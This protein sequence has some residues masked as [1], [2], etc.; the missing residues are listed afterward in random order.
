MVREPVSDS[1]WDL[2]EVVESL[3]EVRRRTVGGSGSTGKDPILTRA[4][5]NKPPMMSRM[6]DPV[7]SS[8]G[9]DLDNQTDNDYH[10]HWIWQSSPQRS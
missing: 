7:N 2:E 8:N 4:T 9:P 10:S 1:V 5:S 3:R 6:V